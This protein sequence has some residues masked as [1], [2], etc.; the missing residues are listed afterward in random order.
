M[1]R[2]MFEQK[3]APYTWFVVEKGEDEEETFPPC[4]SAREIRFIFWMPLNVDY[5]CTL[6]ECH[7][8]SSYL[9]TS[10]SF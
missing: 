2:G 4:N 10:T 8:M 3:G 6:P 1:L 5:T 9:Y 7:D